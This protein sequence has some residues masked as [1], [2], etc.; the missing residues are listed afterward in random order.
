MARKVGK[1]TALDV[2]RLR[3][4][5]LHSDGG[6]L[7]LQISAAGAKSWV[8]RYT[9]H[10]RPHWMGL[11][12]VATVSLANARE[13]A[14]DQRLLL[15]RGKD[16]LAEA[17]AAEARARLIAASEVTFEKAAGQYIAAHEASWGEGY[18]SEWR[19]TLKTYVFPI[20]GKLSV[21]SIDTVLV[22]KVME[23]IWQDIPVTAGRIRG[24][25][26]SILDW[27][28]AR[29]LRT[30]E[31]PARW[32]GHLQNLLAKRPRIR[33]V[34][35]FPALPYAK[36]GDFMADLRSRDHHA[37]APLELTIL[38]ATRSR[39][40]IEAK[41]SE[42][43]LVQRVWTIPAERMKSGRPHRVP[44]SDQ[45]IALLERI[46]KSKMAGD[47]VFPGDKPEKTLK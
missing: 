26:E 27:A 42:F 24:R 34:Q 29:E 3:K 7:W 31:N 2:T 32:R 13:A 12:A 33:K 41:W 16:P 47:H 18:V 4:P 8:F 14:A 36:I 44:L 45:T 6:N 28:K 20:I 25:I 17:R 38:T 46:R 11:G 35:H 22:L 15:F 30:G 1:L 40:A 9:L 5:G 19:S 43:D 37:V 39:E 23:P 21:A 10:R